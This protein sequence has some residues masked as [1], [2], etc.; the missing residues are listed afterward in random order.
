MRASLLILAALLPAPPALAQI[1]TA[2]ATG[3]MFGAYSPF[4]PSPATI[5]GTVTITCTAAGATQVN[6]TVQLGPGSSGNAGARSM[7]NGISRLNYQ[8][9]TTATRSIPWGD[10]TGGT[11]T[12]SDAYTLG[13]L[14]PVIRNYTAYGAIPA[15]Q[16]V[17]PGAYLENLTVMIV[18]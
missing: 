5:T 11:A 7:S 2:S 14:T 12:V 6:Y 4:A 3:L 16:L 9:Y 8:L 17:T 13:G 10:G 1:C 18:Y 15:S